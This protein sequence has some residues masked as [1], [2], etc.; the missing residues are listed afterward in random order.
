VVVLID[1][2]NT[3]GAAALNAFPDAEG[4]FRFDALRPGR[5]RIAAH[6]ASVRWVAS[7]S[8]MTEVNVKGGEATSVELGG[9]Q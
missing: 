9:T 4:H 7:D 6:P 2:A 3:E 1:A 5:Y 8:P